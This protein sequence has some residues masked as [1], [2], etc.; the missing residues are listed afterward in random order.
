MNPQEKFIVK[1][2][3]IEIA[4][5]A[6]FGIF[7]LIYSLVIRSL[8]GELMLNLFMI[9]LLGIAIIGLISEYIY[10][11]RYKLERVNIINFFKSST[12]YVKFLV[13]FCFIGLT[14]I[15]ISA[16]VN[17]FSSIFFKS[18]SLSTNLNALRDFG[19]YLFAFAVIPFFFMKGKEKNNSK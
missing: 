11:R 10:K 13:V 1:I 14:I 19:I 16:Y 7:L 3:I 15:G 12:I 9:V 4:I 2:M 5:L 17:V 18:E 6:S 8:Q